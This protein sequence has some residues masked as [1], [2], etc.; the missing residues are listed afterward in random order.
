MAMSLLS[1]IIGQIAKRMIAWEALASS[2]RSSKA[3]HVG[4]LIRGI[5]LLFDYFGIELGVDLSL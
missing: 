5:T 4:A 3:V 1:L 2:R